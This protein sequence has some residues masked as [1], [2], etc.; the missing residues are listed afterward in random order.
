M[1][2]CA[3]GLDED[4][5]HLLIH[6]FVASKLWW[7]MRNLVFVWYILGYTRHYERVNVQLKLQQREEKTQGMECCSISSYVGHLE[8]KR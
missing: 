1:V 8:G 7:E 3:Q 2:F 5:E 6:C 4:V